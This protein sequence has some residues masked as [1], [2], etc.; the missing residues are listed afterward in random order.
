MRHRR[1]KAH[2]IATTG[3]GRD[4]LVVHRNELRVQGRWSEAVD[5]L[6]SLERRPRLPHVLAQD[7]EVAREAHL[8][9]WIKGKEK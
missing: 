2:V 8:G 1:V 7:G 3:R 4:R 6:E 5:H 9:L